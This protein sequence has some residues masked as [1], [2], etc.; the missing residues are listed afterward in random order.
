MWQ[1][2]SSSTTQ[3]LRLR[4]NQSPR[5]FTPSTNDGG[6][7]LDEDTE[8]K[9]KPPDAEQARN[10][11]EKREYRGVAAPPCGSSA[12]LFPS[13]F[14]E[15][16]TDKCSSPSQGAGVKRSRRSDQAA[17]ATHRSAE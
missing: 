16:K 6:R 11:P 15:R 1:K 4:L 14:C 10:N 9:L 12:K 17:Q 8:S 13:G 2:E 5:N 7:Q 3:P